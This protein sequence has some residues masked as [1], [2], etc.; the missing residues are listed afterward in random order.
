M[1]APA[2]HFTLSADRLKAYTD[3]VVAIAQTLL[4][5]PLLES[6]AGARA[7][8][9]TAT[10][11]LAEERDAVLWFA[12]SF[13]LIGTFWLQ[14]EHIY[15]HIERPTEALHALNALWMFSIVCFPVITSL[16]TLENTDVMQKALY[17]GCM[18]LCSWSLAAAL[19]FALRHP[20]TFGDRPRPL[21]RT[22][23][24]TGGMALLYGVAFVLG[25]AIPG[26]AG[27]FALCVLALMPLL[28]RLLTPVVAR[29]MLRSG[30]SA[31]T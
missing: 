27:Y 20:E 24:A 29:R 8:G 23:A 26:S 13:V 16:L 6:V 3:A 17:L 9:W 31:G 12:V 7:N 22:F 4:I 18:V 25:L 2:R 28:V 5:L 21:A 14:H 30:V 1:D 19:L 11:W 15:R 10:Q